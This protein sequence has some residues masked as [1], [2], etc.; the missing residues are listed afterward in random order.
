[1][2]FSYG[3]RTACVVERLRQ[4]MPPSGWLALSDPVSRFTANQ[5]WEIARLGVYL[6]P[7]NATLKAP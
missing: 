7:Q 5:G 6:E 2:V 3:Q 1:M 4:A